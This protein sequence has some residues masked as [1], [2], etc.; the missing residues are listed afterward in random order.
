MKRKLKHCTL[1]KILNLGFIPI[2]L[3][4]FGDIDYLFKDIT[5]NL[6]FEININKKWVL[7]EKNILKLFKNKKSKLIKKELYSSDYLK[8]KDF[9]NFLKNFNMIYHG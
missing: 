2:W 9:N 6:G 1:H 4:G 3:K 8:F 5:K 7:V